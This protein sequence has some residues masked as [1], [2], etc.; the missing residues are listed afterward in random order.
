MHPSEDGDEVALPLS[1]GEFLLSQWKEHNSRYMEKDESRRPLECTAFP[2]DIMFVPHGW[3]HMVINLDEINVAITHNY[4]GKYNLPSVLRFL[5]EK[6]E[7]ISG[8]RDREES[9]KP[10]ELYHALHAQLEHLYPEILQNALLQSKRWVC[11]AWKDVAS[12]SGGR[13]RKNEQISHKSKLTKAIQNS[14]L[15]TS[16]FSF[17]FM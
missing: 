6:E 8:C 15:E 10:H 5:R 12:A 13:K 17:S 16:G 7:Q 2:G 9:I 1:V 3:W 11:P 14:Q 4:V